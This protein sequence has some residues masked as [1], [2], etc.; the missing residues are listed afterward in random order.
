MAK[1]YKINYKNTQ[2]GWIVEL[3]IDN[4]YFEINTY[5]VAKR[6]E[7]LWVGRMLRKAINRLISK[8]ME[9]SNGEKVRR[10][11]KA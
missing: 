3:Q 7:A 5:S 2:G 8:E 9:K 6:P 1:N 10:H 11:D 4:Q